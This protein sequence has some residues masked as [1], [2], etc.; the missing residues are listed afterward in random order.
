MATGQGVHGFS[1]GTESNEYLQRRGFEIVSLREGVKS[2]REGLD[3]ILDGY[4]PVR[5]SEPF[6]SHNVIADTF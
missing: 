2:I 3:T 4:V 6:G 5:E 1:G